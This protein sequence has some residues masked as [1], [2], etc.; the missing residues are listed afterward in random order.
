[1][2]K[3]VIAKLNP[4]KRSKPASVSEKRIRDGDGQVKTLRTI[5][6]G[7]SSFGEDLKYVFGRNVAK[8]RRDNKRITGRTDVAVTKR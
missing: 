6:I 8:A 1:M 3:I 4:K 7:S 5:D 2:A